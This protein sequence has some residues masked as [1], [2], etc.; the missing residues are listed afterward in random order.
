MRLRS[1]APR[2][3]RLFALLSS[4]SALAA[5]VACGGAET[6]APPDPSASDAASLP[7]TAVAADAGDAAVPGDVGDAVATDGGAGEASS[8]CGR[9][10]AFPVG[11]TTVASI[12]VGGATRSFRVHV[13]PTPK[14][15]APVV[16]VL[17]GGGGSGEQIETKSAEMDP[18]ADR[19]GFVA[20][21]PDGTGA[22]KTWNGGNCC[23][24]AVQD[25]IDDVA[26]VSALLDDLASKLCVDERR[27]FA[28]GM[29]NGAIFA[30]R[31]A[32]E[33]SSRIAAI[34]P[35]AGTIGVPTC[36]PTRPVPILHVHGTSD[37][38]VPWDG[39]V[40][41]GP[42]VTSFVS[43]PTSMEGWRARNGCGATSAITFAQGDGTCTGYDGCAAATVLCAI[44]GGGHSWP[45]G[46]AKTG[47]VDCPGDGAQSTTFAAS[48]AIWAFFAAHPRP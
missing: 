11:T 47:A 24:K 48:E 28:T 33:L 13:P 15:P 19:E 32:C 5:F 17:H 41:C 43:V 22:L 9:A 8:G 12:V 25:G 14:Q 38:H 7:D 36:A 40:G 39:G 45:G 31:L 16:L 20:V 4:A 2:P 6:G 34:A 21:Y 27:V 3:L 44:D 26:F 37:G 18:I 35:V 10:S 42:S 23:G 30:H 29:S 1:V 46:A